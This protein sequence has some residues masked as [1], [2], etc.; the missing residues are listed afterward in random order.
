[1]ETLLSKNG[2]LR[3]FLISGQSNSLGSTA[4]PVE[5]GCPPPFDPLDEA[6]PLYWSNRSSRSGDGPAVL[7][8]DSGGEFKSLQFQQGEG[9]NPIF[10]G[11]EI[12]F[13]RSLAAAGIDNFAIIKASRGGGGNGFWVKDGEDNHMYRHVMETVKGALAALPQQREVVIEALLYVQGESDSDE[14]A[15]VSGER[16]QLLAANLRADLPYAANM[17]VIIGG[18]AAPGERRDIVR[19]EQAALAARDK[20]FTYI[21]TLDL[22]PL[23]Y[24]QLHFNKTAKLELGRRMAAAVTS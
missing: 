9:A 21:D 2:R 8:G 15:V 24:D 18:I 12:G 6:I 5:P 19:R 4:D 10:W 3:L 23:L 17:R 7:L 20:S 11:P 1:M 16:L 22:Q 13:G 14:Q